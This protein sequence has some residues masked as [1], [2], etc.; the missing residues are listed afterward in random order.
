MLRHLVATQP[1]PLVTSLIAEAADSD[2]VNSAQSAHDYAAARLDDMSAIVPPGLAADIL[3]Q[4]DE[5]T[6]EWGRAP[7]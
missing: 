7:L 1:E 4:F 5:K 2:D 3:N 6:R